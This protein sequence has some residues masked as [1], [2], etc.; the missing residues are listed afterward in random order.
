MVFNHWS[1]HLL[2]L[3]LLD[4]TNYEI[5][6]IFYYVCGSQGG[7]FLDSFLE[8]YDC[9]YFIYE[10]LRVFLILGSYFFSDLGSKRVSASIFFVFSF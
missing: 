8:D 6:F 4:L 5:K 10:L 2:L 7:Y 9:F 3:F 1:V